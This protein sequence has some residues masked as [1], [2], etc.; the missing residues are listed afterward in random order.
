MHPGVRTRTRGSATPARVAGRS[1]R[2][3]ALSGVI[4]SAACSV[5][6]PIS[7]AAADDDFSD[8]RIPSNRSL[9]WTAGFGARAV[10]EDLSLSSSQNSASYL[11][12]NGASRFLWFSDSDPALTSLDVNLLAQG[13]R[14]HQ[15][16]ESQSIVP[17]ASSAQV[18]GRKDQQMVERWSLSAGHR[19]YPWA[20]PLGIGASVYLS[21]DFSQSWLI[22]STEALFVAPWYTLQ[23]TQSDNF[24]TWT[25]YHAV[26]ASASA[27][28]G[29]VRNATGIY[30][31]LVLER[32]LLETGALTRPL[33]PAGRQR[34][35]E[36]L[37]LRS[38]FGT[39]HERPG[40]GL[41][42]EIERVLAADGALREGGL[43]PYTVLR[44]AEPHLGPTGRLAADGVPVSPATRLTGFF[45]GLQLF[46]GHVN[47]IERRDGGFSSQT[48]QDGTIIGAR[49]GTYS[50]RTDESFDRVSGGATGEVHLAI[51]PPWQLDAN[52][53]VLLGL[54]RQENDLA[55]S[56]QISLV[57]LAAD[58]WTA[59]A[60]AR[61]QWYDDERTNGPTAGDSWGWDVGT[62]VRW[63]FEDRAAIELSAME[64]QGWRRGDASSHLFHRGL[65]V[66]LGVTYRFAG[67][68]ETPGFFAG[69][70]APPPV[71]RAQP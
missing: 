67:W 17:P 40:R 1:L 42:R 41:W 36:V 28:W 8:F 2:A 70:T 43:D 50:A 57:W 16:Q 22:Q 38:A 33:S 21:G 60:N 62:T 58:R 9:L 69:A 65:G 7:R 24:E 45:A 14:Q 68:I 23:N 20:A 59:I 12:A 10:G 26:A 54:R 52:S 47:R 66:S 13:S 15:D 4:A 3:Q 39:V 46:D 5:V 55:V 25:Y 63:Y 19:S 35:A 31:A 29:R 49:T 30:D 37:Y 44:A 56:S 51:G 64:Q 71:P 11:G 53:A 34:L 27:G 6:F 18:T 48:V 61:H 32:R